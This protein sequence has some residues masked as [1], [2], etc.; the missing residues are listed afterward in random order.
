MHPYGH[1]ALRDL[2]IAS[3]LPEALK[4]RRVTQ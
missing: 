4:I 1:Y 2:T 3:R